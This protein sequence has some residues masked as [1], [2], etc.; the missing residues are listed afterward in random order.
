MAP[1]SL[2]AGL[3][4]EGTGAGAAPGVQL[5]G[6]P[7]SSLR[8]EL[9][10]ATDTASP[11]SLAAAGPGGDD[12]HGGP[13][14]DREGGPGGDREG[15]AS[16]SGG[17][18]QKRAGCARGGSMCTGGLPGAPQCSLHS[19]TGTGRCLCCK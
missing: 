8:T 7:R 5:A 14:S 11:A 19:G 15:G 4:G 6:R 10:N 16:E 9:S 17:R 12:R 18:P 1:V 2:H 3:R 13:G